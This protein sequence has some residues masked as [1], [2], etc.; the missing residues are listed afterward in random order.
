[1]L[2]KTKPPGF[3]L[4]TSPKPVDDVVDCPKMDVLLD[5]PK[6]GAGG[7]LDWS[8]VSLAAAASFVNPKNPV[9]L[10]KM[11]GLDDDES[12]AV[13]VVVVVPKMEAVG[14]VA[15]AAVVV[16]ASAIDANGFLAF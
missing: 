9:E 14:V 12:D 10:P 3:A 6:R 1:M 16:L 15:V 5:D 2:P 4:F 13:G 8:S 7:V 11:D